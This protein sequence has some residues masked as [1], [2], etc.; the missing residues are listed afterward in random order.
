MGVHAVQRVN[1]VRKGLAFMKREG[2]RRRGREGESGQGLMNASTFIGETSRINRASPAQCFSICPSAHSE[3][4][5][6]TSP[7]NQMRGG[8]MADS[9]KCGL[10]FRESC[11]TSKGFPGRV[12]REAGVSFF[13]IGEL[14]LRAGVLIGLSLCWLL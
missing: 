12:E 6:N 8:L 11:T 10:V 4:K 2:G 13:R 1:L 5:Q 9:S 3:H 14:E 7:H